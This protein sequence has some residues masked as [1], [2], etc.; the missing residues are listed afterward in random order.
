MGP[1][2][3]CDDRLER[4]DVERLFGNDLF[5]PAVFVLDLLQP[6][7][8]A[9]LHP[10]VLCLPAVIRLLTDPVRA[11]QVGDLP[12]GFAFFHDRQDLLVRVCAPFHRSSSERR[13]P[14]YAWRI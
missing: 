11:T 14:F 2:L 12:P 7:H 1:T 3:F 8:L 6:L 13:A 9:E 5:K 10:A 4:L